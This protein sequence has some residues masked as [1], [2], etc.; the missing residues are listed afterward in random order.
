VASA[1]LYSEHPTWQWASLVNRAEQFLLEAIRGGNTPVQVQAAL[2]VAVSRWQEMQGTGVLP[3]EIESTSVS[4]VVLCFAGSHDL[5]VDLMG[6][7]LKEKVPALSFSIEYV[8]S[9]GGLMALAQAEADIAG[10]HLWDEATDDYNI[11][12]IQRL[13]PGHRMVL[14]TVAHR[15]L[16][17]MTPS[18][19]PLNLQSLSDLTQSEVRLVNRQPGSGTRVWLEAQLKALTISPETIAGYDREETT[20]LA[21]A[22][23]IDRDEANV[24]LGIHAAA[25]AFELTFVPLT[26]ERY[27]L[28]F[29]EKVWNTQPTQELVRIIRS[30][31]FKEK[32]TAFG[33]YDT[34]Q[35]GREI[36]VS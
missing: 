34:S 20:H 23:A 30:S 24:G 29:S 13:L 12:F 8:G 9:L 27:D 4:K 10:T 11:P 1:A 19:N 7:I 25:A 22:R 16:G 32:V 31:E 6:R 35:T 28:V 21:V 14:V 2:S 5:A 18:G 17:L 15:S 26:Q 36:W 33:G 3:L